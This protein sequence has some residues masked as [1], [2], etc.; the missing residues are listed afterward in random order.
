MVVPTGQEEVQRERR[1]PGARRPLNDIHLAAQHAAA[2]EQVKPG[3]SCR[4]PGGRTRGNRCVRLRLARRLSSHVT[5]PHGGMHAVTVSR[6]RV[7]VYRRC[8]QVGMPEEY[9]IRQRGGGNALSR[10]TS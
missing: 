9:H 1:F 4:R 7:G 5:P 10:E 3:N 8:Q 2:E 6:T